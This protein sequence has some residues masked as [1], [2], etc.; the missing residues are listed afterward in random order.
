M[1]PAGSSRGFTLIE[2]LVAMVVMGAAATALFGLLSSS[3]FNLRK[4]EDV[5]RYQLAAEDVMNRLQFVSTFPAEGKLNGR[6]ADLDATWNVTVT[7]WFPA[8]LQ[9]KPAQA[10][11]KID[12][13]L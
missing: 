11:M 2:V 12:V 7:P 4:L 8:T 1:R 6:T 13:N 3:L 5:H 10:I 9:E